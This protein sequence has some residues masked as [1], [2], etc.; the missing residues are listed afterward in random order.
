VEPVPRR[1]RIAD[2]ARIAGVGVGT[3]SRVLNGNPRVSEATRSAVLATIDAL[4]YRPSRHGRRLSLG[5]S[6][7]VG[8]VVPFFAQPS[9]TERMKGFLDGLSG[10]RYDLGLFDVETPEERREHFANLARGDRAD[11]VLVVS[12]SP[13]DAEV[14]AF[15]AAGLPVVLVD[16]EHPRLPSI[17]VDDVHGAYIATRYL[18]DLG[19][20]RIA[21]VGDVQDSPLGLVSGARR[22][23]GY[24]RALHDAGVEPDASYVREG[25]LGREATHRLTGELLGL[26]E[27]PTAIFASTDVQALCVLEAAERVGL[28]VPGSLSVVGFD[29]LEAAACAGLTTVR[30]PLRAGGRRGAELLLA[31][32]EGPGPAPGTETLPLELVVRRTT[33]PPRTHGS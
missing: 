14:D 16:A 19:H 17:V 7:T 18:L 11:G 25:P 22:R 32:L 26:D 30:Q 15:A 4:D 12:L 6:L 20:R 33:A 13:T 31:S 21:F 3:V 10:S 24:E 1:L 8:V 5:R 28:S 27:Q 23:E 29:D 2:V 9:V